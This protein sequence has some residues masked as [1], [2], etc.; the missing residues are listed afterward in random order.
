MFT[1][2]LKTMI[3]K[4]FQNF[5]FRTPAYSLDKYKQYIQELENEN[6]EVLLSDNYFLE[7]VLIASPV[8][9][10]EIQKYKSGK[11]PEK[12]KPRLFSSLLRYFTRMSWRCTP[13]GLFSGCSVGIL[14]SEN[15]VILPSQ[16]KSKRHTRLDMNYLCALILAVSKKEEIRSKIKYYPNTSLYRVGDKLRYVEYT[17]QNAN[18]THKIVSVDNSTYLQIILA[19]AEKGAEIDFLAN[20]IAIEDITFEEAKD[21]IIDLIENQVLVSELEPAV[22]GNDVLNTFINKLCVIDEDLEVVKLLSDI[23]KQLKHIDQLPIGETISF[24]SEIISNIRDLG[25]DFDVKYLFQVDIVKT[26]IQANISYN[27]IRNIQDAIIFINRLTS[28]Y[29]CMSSN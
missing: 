17:F 23:Q 13:F 27:Y 22:T 24:Y 4:P 3:Y 9:Y 7:A 16:K 15:K 5:I 25:I 18:R 21:F 8:L 19:A 26:P 14:S 29:T 2:K 20:I 1:I 6:Y 10:D 12:Q 28:S 11:L